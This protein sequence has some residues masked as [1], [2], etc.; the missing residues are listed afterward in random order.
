MTNALA[1]AVQGMQNDLYGMDMI[2][3]NVANISTP[4]Y[5]RELASSQSFSDALQNAS[6]DGSN[7][8]IGVSLPV[9]TSIL[10][11]TAGPVKYTG[12]PL[13]LAIGGNAYFLVNTPAGPAYSRA[14][15][16]HLDATGRLVNQN[17]YPVAGRSGD[18]VVQGNVSPTIAANGEI[19]ANGVVIDQ[20]R[21]V[22]FSE[23]PNLQPQG[24]GLLVPAKEEAQPIDQPNATVQV[25]YLE[26]S[27]VSQLD[28]M[29]NMI[30]TYRNFESLQK[31][32][33]GYDQQM[34]DAIQQ[35]G[36]F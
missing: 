4:G 30:G 26:G 17:G 27:N 11:T 34:G 29:V 2:S 31:L 33:Q 12:R 25:G 9:I 21:L 14:G 24:D 20:I 5:R 23:N 15:N 18:I 6:L 19:T 10:D 28:E 22:G 36:R 13:D 3:Q 16:F 8:Q 32:F 35:L 7:N 1:I